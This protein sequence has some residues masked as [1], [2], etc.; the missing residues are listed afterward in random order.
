MNIFYQIVNISEKWVTKN[1]DELVALFASM[2]HSSMKRH[3]SFGPSQNAHRIV[4][5][6][7]MNH[8]LISNIIYEKEWPWNG[9]AK[10]DEHFGP[11]K[12]QKRSN[13][14][15]NKII[16]RTLLKRFFDFYFSGK[17]LWKLINS[18]NINFETIKR[19]YGRRIKSSLPRYAPKLYDYDTLEELTDAII[20]KALEEY[21]VITRDGIF[22]FE[23]F[24]A[25]WYKWF[26]KE[27]RNKKWRSWDVFLSAIHDRDGFLSDRQAYKDFKD[28][29]INNLSNQQDHDLN[30]L[31]IW[32]LETYLSWL[33]EI[34]L[35]AL[36]EQLGVRCV[37]WE[38]FD[39]NSPLTEIE[40]K[41]VYQKLLETLN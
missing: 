23:D 21:K 3:L 31:D 25:T 28:R 36:L 15:L 41:A 4:D 32:L 8:D 20:L 26:L 34:E 24:F 18:L 11:L 16:A 37:N 19:I 39:C 38:T 10:S 9:E 7:V 1:S 6:V 27:L 33:S 35:Q 13:R 2:V 12:F 40:T 29:E 22:P 17:N 5:L 30:D 14:E